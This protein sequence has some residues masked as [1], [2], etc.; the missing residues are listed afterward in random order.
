MNHLFSAATRSYISPILGFLFAASAVTIASGLA[1]LGSLDKVI[2][3]VIIFLGFAS[4]ISFTRILERRL[5]VEAK[6]DFEKSHDKRRI[7]L[8]DAN[9]KPM[10]DISIASL[11]RVC[12]MQGRPFSVMAAGGPTM[13]PQLTL[14]VAA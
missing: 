6:R 2:A 11:E 9:K 7:I 4:C 12:T 8:R 5:R 3:T 1:T 13:K 10:V 14:E